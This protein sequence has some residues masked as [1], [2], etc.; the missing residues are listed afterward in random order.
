LLKPD[1]WVEAEY[2]VNSDAW[3]FK[4]NRTAFMP[5]CI[6]N[7]IALQP[8]GW[9]AAYMGLA[10]KSQKDPRFRNLGGNTTL[11]QNILNGE[12]TLTTRTRLTQVSKAGDMTIEQFEFQ[13]FQSDL[14][15]Y[16]GDTSFGFFT[17]EALAIQTGIHGGSENAY[18]PGVEKIKNA[19]SFII[20]AE[21]PFTPV[22][23]K[24]D[25]APS[26]A[27]P[28]KAVLMLDQID[29]Y[30]PD[31]GPYGL[32]FIRGIKKVD[33]DE[34]FFKAHF[35]QDPVCPGS[36]GIESFLQL[37]R[38]IAIDRFKHLE[39]SHSFELS[40]KTPH[41]WIYRGQILPDNKKIEVEAVVT[42]ISDKPNPEVFANGYLKVDGL[43]IYKMDNF[44]FR[45][46]PLK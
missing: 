14:K 2:D 39:N 28:A 35:F 17:K 3:Y 24:I 12:N 43:Y 44:G 40:T 9:L 19:K 16:E 33:P 10:L 20:K 25:Q 27:M 32:G 21:A 42:K 5:Y 6:I 18:V 26:L 34:W 31:G 38:F 7:E 45:L 36:L 41:N 1:G 8:C 13:V 30:I 15:I 46:V 22:D 11:Y 4:A 37:I 23:N 29:T